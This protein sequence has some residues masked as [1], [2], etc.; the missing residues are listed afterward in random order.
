[1]EKIFM[2]VKEILTLIA[3]F[4]LAGFPKPPTI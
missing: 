4:R 2:A 1:M 3:T